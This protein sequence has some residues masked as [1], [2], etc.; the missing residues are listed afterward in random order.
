MCDEKLKI[1]SSNKFEI[2]IYCE[3]VKIKES[4]N[5]RILVKGQ[6][7]K[8]EEL[9]ELNDIYQSVIRKYLLGIYKEQDWY[10]TF[11]LY[12]EQE[13]KEFHDILRHAVFQQEGF[14]RLPVGMTKE[15]LYIAEQTDLYALDKYEKMKKEFKL[16]E[17]D[18]FLYGKE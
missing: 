6:Q 12:V 8:K 11:L 16:I 14:Y 1:R 13:T 15:K 10:L 4:I 3:E 5:I 2:W 7:L 9:H 18:L 17:R